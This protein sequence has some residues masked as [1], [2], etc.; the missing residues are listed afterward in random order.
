MLNILPATMPVL[1]QKL[2]IIVQNL[3]RLLRALWEIGFI[4]YDKNKD[5]WQLSSKGKCFKKY[6]FCLK[7]QQCGQGLPLKRIGLKIADILSRSQYLHL[8]LLRRKKHQKDRKIAF[9]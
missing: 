2:N 8:N 5:L 9:Y 1:S 3:E 7:Q 4:D 6:H